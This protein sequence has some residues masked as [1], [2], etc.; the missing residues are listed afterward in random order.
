MGTVTRADVSAESGIRAV[1]R[2]HHRAFWIVGY[3]FAVTMAFTTL[4]APLYVL[5]QARDGFDTFM[6]TVIFA[7]YALGVAG[8]LYLFGHLSDWAGRRRMVLLAV[9]TNMIA[10]VLFLTWPTT[11]GLIVA[12]LVSGVSVG[13]LTATAT[14]YLNELHAAARPDAPPTR[15]EVVSTAANLGGLGLGA[16][17][18]GLL[19]QYAGHALVIPYLVSEAMMLL[20]AVALALVPETVTPP[21]RRPAYRPQHVSVPSANRATFLAAAVTGAAVFALFGIFTSVAPSLIAGLLHDTSHAVAGVVTFA[22]FGASATAQ[23]L[24]GRA[25]RRVQ[26]GAGLLAL[27][28]G[29]AMVTAAAWLPSF[30]LLVA[31]GIV[32]GAGAGAAFRGAIGS[33]IAIT[34]PEVRG[35]GLAGVFLGA[36]AGMA[37]TVVGLGVATLWVSMQVAVLGFAIVLTVAVL[38]VARRVAVLPVSTPS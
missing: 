25:G 17:L 33:A 36:Y 4:P 27:V 20:G 34:P 30:W 7:A 21:P 31:G 14:A 5:Y 23:I 12:R 24:L 38:A 18:S 10:G 26:S 16:L 9:L 37:V 3:V 13:M 15:S 35:E 19:A 8:S 11:A 2:R 6:I 29:L 32:A 1:P 22:V 28:T